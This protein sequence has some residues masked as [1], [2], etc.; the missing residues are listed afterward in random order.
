MKEKGWMEAT[1]EAAAKRKKRT[2]GRGWIKKKVEGGKESTDHKDRLNIGRESKRLKYR[3][4]SPISEYL[5]KKGL[6]K[7]VNKQRS[8]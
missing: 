6:K 5:K 4:R 2:G 1:R 3:K 8:R 7:D